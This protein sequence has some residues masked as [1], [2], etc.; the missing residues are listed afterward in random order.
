MLIS[1]LYENYIKVLTDQK[2]K[3]IQFKRKMGKKYKQAVH[4]KRN[5]NGPKKKDKLSQEMQI[6]KKKKCKLKSDIIFTS[7]K[8][9]C[10]RKPSFRPENRNVN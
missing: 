3:S 4:K 5:T 9:R 8:V 1:L 7:K 2:W 6:K 10:F